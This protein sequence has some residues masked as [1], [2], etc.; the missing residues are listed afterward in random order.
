MDEL[1]SPQ[2]S[3]ALGLAALLLVMGFRLARPGRA[4]EWGA[5]VAYLAAVVAQILGAR[6]I[7]PGAVVQ[8]GAASRIVGAVLLV[9]GLIMAG[10]PAR[11]RRRAAAGVATARERIPGRMDPVY[12]GLAVVLLGHLLREPSAAG[13]IAVGLAAPFLAWPAVT[14]MRAPGQA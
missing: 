8:A 10:T 4:R 3:L 5:L 9:V 7:L 12:A 2:G 11:A 14:A 1:T 6:G 13:V